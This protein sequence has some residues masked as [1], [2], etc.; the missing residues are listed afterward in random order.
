MLGLPLALHIF[1]VVFYDSGEEVTTPPL[2]CGFGGK[3][4]KYLVVIS[5]Y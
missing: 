4:A 5:K 2:T 3:G 1:P